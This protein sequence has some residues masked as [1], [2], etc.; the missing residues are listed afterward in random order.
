MR[1]MMYCNGRFPCREHDGG[2]I[3]SSAGYG[4]VMHSMSHPVFLITTTLSN[5]HIGP[6]LWLSYDARVIQPW[7]QHIQAKSASEHVGLDNISFAREQ[8]PWNYSTKSETERPCFK[9]GLRPQGWSMLPQKDYVSHIFR[10]VGY[11]VTH[12]K[13]VI[14]PSL[15]P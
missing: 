13:I 15:R 10:A 2:L 5:T 6:L 14:Y 9:E 11:I 4:S 1:A 7:K 3:G 8:C 12:C